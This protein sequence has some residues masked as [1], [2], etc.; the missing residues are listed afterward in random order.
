MQLCIF[1]DIQ[2]RGFLPLAY[3]RPV[4]DLRCGATT[5]GE[6]I[7]ACLPRTPVSLRVRP[8]MAEFWLEEERTVPVNSLSADDTWFV[9]AR[10]VADERLAKLLRRKKPR[11]CAYLS[12]GE[13]AA[14]YVEGKNVHSA[15]GSRHELPGPDNFTGFPT[16]SFEGTLVRH[17]W[18]LVSHCAREIEKDFANRSAGR[19]NGGRARVQR[20]AY[21]LNRKNIRLSSG[22][23][24]QPGA[25]IDAGDGPVILGRNVTVMAHAFIQGPACIGDGSVIKAGAKIYHGTS[26]GPRCKVGGEVEAS[27]IQSYSNKQHDGFLGHSYIGSWV[28]IGAGTNTSD[29]KNT[30]GRVSVRLADEEIDT[31]LQFVGLTMGDHSKT[32]IGALFSTGTVVGVSCNLLGPA[33][34]PKYVPSFSWGEKGAFT[35]YDPDKAVVTAERVMAR[36]D[37]RMGSAYERRMREVFATTAAE[38]RKGGIA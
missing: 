22:S 29:L 4:S 9:N 7:A 27:I 13:L 31:G 30:Y 20:G 2:Y 15:G 21:L 37:I 10:A 32:G 33:P 25:V 24:V 23:V 28:N 6:K 18:D 17:P 36:R 3:L 35:V 26:I 19:G 12:N 8:D 16:E 14:V 34:P 38:R 11:Q 1:E 5:L